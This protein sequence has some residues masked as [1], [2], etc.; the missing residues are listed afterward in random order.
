MRHPI[1]ALVLLIAALLSA[2]T[3]EAQKD[4]KDDIM[5]ANERFMSLFAAGDAPAFVEGMYTDDAVVMPPNSPVV[6]GK[7]NLVAMWG[8]MMEADITPKVMTGS[9][10]AYGKTAIEEGTVEIY[11]GDDKVDVMKYIVIWKKDGKTW[12]MHRDIWSSNMPVQ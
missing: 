6:T 1:L 3:T 2:S 4:V 11:S 10:M 9:A 12:K 7:E 8:G 5:E